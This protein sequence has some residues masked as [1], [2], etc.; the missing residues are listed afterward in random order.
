M[1]CLDK[2]DPIVQQHMRPILQGLQEQVAVYMRNNPEEANSKTLR[3]F[4]MAIQSL[5]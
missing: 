1:I 3:I 4:V 2:T 5:V